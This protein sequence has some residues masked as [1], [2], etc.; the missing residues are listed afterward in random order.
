[1]LRIRV[2]VTEGL[3]SFPVRAPGLPWRPR[4]LVPVRH[5]PAPP[6]PG[7]AVPGAGP[8]VAV[9]RGEA[10]RCRGPTASAAG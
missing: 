8:G 2:P 1:M 9:H 6:G 7:N 3:P 10:P 5:P 4:A